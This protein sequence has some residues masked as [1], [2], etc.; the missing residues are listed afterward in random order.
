MSRSLPASF[1]TARNELRASDPW[2][3]LFEFEIPTTPPTRLRL[4]ANPEA[5]TFGTDSDGNALTYSPFPIRIGTM[6]QTSEGDIPS[7]DITIGNPDRILS[8]YIETYDGMIGQP[9]KAILV[10]SGDLANP[11]SKLEDRGEIRLCTVG[12]NSVVVRVSTY[13][14]YQRRFPPFRYVSRTCRHQF[15]DVNCGYAIPAGAT[16][17]TGGGY[18]VCSK[19]LAACEARGADE[20]ARNVEVLHPQR[21]GGWRGIPRQ[22]GSV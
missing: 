19:S 9:V 14:L 20:L 8:A 10:N 18:N 16:N 1:E 4:A 6:R 22:S 21:F 3:W 2:I 13:S 15:G 5:V 17:T 11:R 7:V 12:G